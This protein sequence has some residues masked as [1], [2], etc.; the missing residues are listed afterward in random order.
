MTMPARI[1]RTALAVAGGILVCLGIL[2]V[3]IHTPPVR[4][5]IFAWLQKQARAKGVALSAASLNFNLP[6]GWVELRQVTATR[7]PSEGTSPFLRADRLHFE[8]GLRALLGGSIVIN[9]AVAGNLA[10]D[11]AI[12][13]QGRSN[14]PN[15]GGDSGQPADELPAFLI[16]RLAATGSFKFDDR[17]HSIEA[18]IPAWKL[19][20]NG[21]QTPY[22]QSVLLDLGQAAALR[23]EGREL[24]VESLHLG[25]SFNRRSADIEDLR[26]ATPAG[27][28]TASGSIKGFADPELDLKL[29][30]GFDLAPLIRLGGVSLPEA[31]DGRLQASIQTHGKLS[32]L[33][34][35][36]AVSVPDL[37][38]A[39]FRNV[40]VKAQAGW[41]R[42]TGVVE[43]QSASIAAP[44]GNIALTAHWAGSGPKDANR[45]SAQISRADL[46]RLS[47]DFKLPVEIASTADGPVDV[48]W[49]GLAFEAAAADT[50]LRLTPLSE[51]AA[52]DS[53]PLSGDIKASVRNRRVDVAA[54]SLH[55][56]GAVIDGGVTV[57]LPAGG[58]TGQIRAEIDD[59]GD[60]VANAQAFSGEASTGLIAD[61]RV[62]GR[63]E[64]NLDIGGTLASPAAT[65]VLSG[66]GIQFGPAR[67]AGIH[68]LA[69]YDPTRVTVK[70]FRLA[71][72]GSELTAAGSV[73]L[74]GPDRPIDFNGSM[75]GISIPRMLAVFGQKLPVTGAASANIQAKGTLNHPQISLDLKGAEMAAYGEPLGELSAL[76]SLANGT[77]KLTSLRLQPP[78]GSGAVTAEGT[79]DTGSKILG[80][81][82][83]GSGVNLRGL[84]VPGV[85]PVRGIVN[86]AADASG[87]LDNPSAGISL[88]IRDANI[89]GRALGSIET[90]SDIANHM[91]KVSVTAPD[92]QLSAN[93]EAKTD[94]PYP[95]SVSLDLKDTDL[96]RLPLG[97]KAP[98][99]RGRLTAHLDAAGEPEKWRDGSASLTVSNLQMETAAGGVR[100]AG[101]LKLDYARRTLKVLAAELAGPKST[102]SM[103][104][105]MPVEAAAGTGS[106]H[107]SGKLDLSALA[108]LLDKDAGF[109]LAGKADLA[110]DLRGSLEKFEPSATLTLRAGEVVAAALKSPLTGIEADA[111]LDHGQIAVSRIHATLG[112]GT[113]DGEGVIPLAYFPLPEQVVLPPAS[114][115]RFNADVKGLTLESLSTLPEKI[116]G[117]I[118]MH[119]E[120]QSSAPNL[121]SVRAT[122][123]FPEL[124]L[125]LGGVAIAPDAPPVLLLEKSEVRVDRFTLKGPETEIQ[126]AGRASLPSGELHDVR[127]SGHTDAALLSSISSNVSAAGP[128]E[129]AVSAAGQPAQPAING[130]L[131]MDNG[132]VGLTSPRIDLSDLKIRLGLHDPR[133][134]IEQFEGALNGGTLVVKGGL[135]VRPELQPDLTISAANVYLDFPAG[136]RTLSRVNLHLRPQAQSLLLSGDMKIDEGSYT[137]VL[138]LQGPL[139]SF[140]RSGGG[141]ALIEERSPLLAR[142]RYDVAVKTVD[143]IVVDN[144]LG[145]L[146]LTA[147]LRLLGS[148][149]RPGLTG[150]V[151]IGE[152]GT[153]RLQENNYV[154]ESGSIAFVNETKIDPQ[155][156][157]EASTKVRN[158]TITV[159]VGADS[160]GE[161]STNFTSDDTTDTRADIIALLLTGRTSEELQGREVNAA[162]EQAALSLLAGSVTGRLSQQLQGSLGLSRVR[163]EPDL[164]STEAD[165]TARLT[166][167]QDL[168][169]ALELIYSMNLRNSSDQILKVNYQLARRF[170]ISGTK[171]ADNSYRFDFKHDL[172]F[173]GARTESRARKK[174]P[175][176][177]VG[178]VNFTGNLQLP[179][180]TLEGKFK[181]KPGSRYDFFRLRKGLDRLEA[182]YVK[183]G[184]LEA[185]VR[186][187]REARGEDLVDLTV[188]IEAG[189]QVS[190]V[191]EGWNAPGRLRNRIRTDWDRGFFDTQRFEMALAEIRR[192]LGAKGFLRPNIEHEA[193][194]AGGRKKVIFTVERGTRYSGTE[195]VFDGAR[196][197]KPKTL[198]TQL[199]KAKLVDKLQSNP[200][201]V[202]D[203]LAA[204]YHQQGFLDAGVSVPEFRYDEVPTKARVHF[205]IVEGPK[206]NWGKLKIDGAAAL[207]PEEFAKTAELET[208][209]PYTPEAA[210]VSR[211]HIED[212]YWK[213]GYRNVV[214]DYG[215]TRNPRLAQVDVAAKVQEGARSVVQSIEVQGT[216]QTSPAFVKRQIEFQPGDALDYTKTSLSRR[217]LYDTGAFRSVE[218]QSVPVPDENP[219]VAAKLQHVKLLASVQEKSPYQLRYGGFYDTDRGPGAIVEFWNRNS[220][221][222]GRVVGGRLRYDGDVK[223][224][225]VFFSQP[226][227]RSFPLRTDTSF[228]LR[229]ETQAGFITDRTGVS[230]QQEVRL[231]NRLILTYG[232]RLER[233]HTY[234][235]DP[236]AFIPF[237]VTLRV[238]PLTAT[239]S[240]DSRDDILDATRGSFTSHAVE[241]AIGKLGSSLLFTRYF[242]QYFKYIPLTAPAPVP[243]GKGLLKPRV[244][245]AGGVRVGLAKGLGGQEVIRSER[246]F[247]GGGTTI[248]GYKQDTLGPVDFLDRPA[249]GNAMLVINNELRFP[250]FK[251]FDAASFLDIGN[252]Y[253]K[254]GDFSLAD[255]RKTAGAGLRVRTPYFLLRLDYGFKLDRRTGESRG[256][257]FFSIGQAF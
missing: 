170:A 33:K 54:L 71:W 160:R 93:I 123:T 57:A 218:I 125:D 136:L 50:R 108:P 55:S 226:L 223:E 32:A 206:Y 81:R 74:V 216:E 87:S 198:E 147:A 80:L 22:R 96:S 27:N 56:M 148:F 122:L 250:V 76:A 225:R 89:D 130:S 5:T 129:F 204:Y 29:V 128:I 166:V 149:Y 144:N 161:M 234:D 75:T 238:A 15:F 253:P 163:I 23:Y 119:L 193:K 82:L 120:A 248:R 20:I 103:Q 138:D 256:A 116:K 208:G 30:A 224:A 97:E 221:G 58:M 124:N 1:W 51:M 2:L 151:D 178:K 98:P 110:A 150:R 233:A 152:G 251:M 107:L 106:L 228:F 158:R 249:G 219:D 3:A 26:L 197:I 207:T 83:R 141:V 69:D 231:R 99:L 159:T 209:K 182:L 142:L 18:R 62:A 190:F 215:L 242:G 25:G 101:D 227:M 156:N 175:E 115:A 16:S 199:K 31:V 137:E 195:L 17:A 113:I 70:E 7:E 66:S 192:E 102:L 210:G 9:D 183:K 252:L 247:S 73:G 171:Q 68:A 24:P 38:A 165:P 100:N 180:K 185:R 121:D 21:Q 40:Q 53:I 65:A 91:A 72:E 111:A 189:P 217:Q 229:R 177:R 154:I 169:R 173:G 232:Y 63:A 237:D 88:S 44:E 118:G 12:D 143:P 240:R 126:L 146:E 153:L 49:Q 64:V 43:V 145:K 19:A 92:F 39:P 236:N 243:F 77:V 45:V 203:F 168:T 202:R 179:V 14:L 246:F 135:Q 90:R 104:G 230:M 244:I 59:L 172:R 211:E 78:G 134:E 47:R 241:Y 239:L 48:R 52:K 187:S 34:A 84:E 176:R 86:I 157:L 174:G 191:Y 140:L 105:E 220:L 212:A 222:G 117:R 4:Q 79:F 131:R 28:L 13:P 164:I 67:D 201:D 139:M 109:T 46:A 196:G 133:I 60:V 114:Q 95:L 245:Y 6:A 167:G 186:Q 181:V 85:G 132:R 162:G 94:S 235:S 184:Y 200:A 254:L 37:A 8:V 205:S 41:S 155:F 36:A 61:E 194:L 255:V 214:V 112:T 11:I 35:D 213:K 188:N 10:I 127:L 42:A 257:W